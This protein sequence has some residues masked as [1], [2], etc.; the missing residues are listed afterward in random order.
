MKDIRSLFPGA[1]SQVYL[2]IGVRGLIGTPTREAVDQHLDMRQAGTGGKEELRAK[3]E[4][5]R[6][7]FASLIGA[8]ATD[9]A[10]TKN[11]SEGLNM[12]AESL[13]WRAGDNVVFCPE[14][15]HPNNVFLWYN[16]RERRDIELRTIDPEDNR[17]PSRAIA[18]AID[19]RTRVVT[20]SHVSFAP[21][22]VTDL[23]PISDAASRHGALVLLDA[24]QSIGSLDVDVGTLGVDAL[25]VATQKSLLSLYGFGF[26]WIR[27]EV[28]DRLTPCHVA[29]YGVDLGDDAHEPALGAGELR[30]REGARRFDLGNF[31]YLGA[32]AA[33]AAIDLL[34]SIGMP[35]VERHVCGLARQ[36]AEGLLEVGLP[37]VGGDL[38]DDLAHIVCVGERGG[39][40]HD[41]ADD[42]VMNSLYSYL[43][44][45]GVVLS[46]RRGVLRLSV[47]VYNNESDITRVM[48]LARAWCEGA[49]Q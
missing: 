45:N 16:M 26:L 9:V 29:R 21:G 11:V 48:E 31:N 34:R 2:D 6:E 12:F 40:R 44:A 18:A 3:A 10:L 23:R 42:P 30:F 24:A 35:H 15:E 49:E 37:V 43:T 14:L 47:G 4:H 46:I 22:F 33:G 32:A 38:R 20:A 8:D 17:V 7:S 25:T 27:R 36:L 13:P 5:A 39:G 19:A 28:A 41:T 1:E